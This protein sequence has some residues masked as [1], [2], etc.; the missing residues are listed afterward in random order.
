[1]LNN[2]DTNKMIDK[3]EIINKTKLATV[4]EVTLLRK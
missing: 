1:M 2:F 4:N 3:G